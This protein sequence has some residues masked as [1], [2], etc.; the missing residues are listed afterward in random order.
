VQN[1]DSESTQRYFFNSY[2][3]RL[4][5]TIT[6]STT[7]FQGF[8]APSVLFYVV[9][10]IYHPLTGAAKSGFDDFVNSTCNKASGTCLFSWLLLQMARGPETA[11]EETRALAT[12]SIIRFPRTGLLAHSNFRLARNPTIDIANRQ[13]RSTSRLPGT[14]LLDEWIGD[15]PLIAEVVA[16]QLAKITCP[17]GRQYIQNRF[18]RQ[19]ASP[20]PDARASAL[21]LALLRRLR[22][23]SNRQVNE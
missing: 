13:S 23:H 12:V 2:V 18:Q 21:R 20:A 11:F 4:R 8:A 7:Y 19:S 15:L 1:S 3:A 16:S 10:S 22:W 9:E 17:T 14:N 6:L 5:Y